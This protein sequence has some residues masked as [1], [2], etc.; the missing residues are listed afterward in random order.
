[1]KKFIILLEFS[2]L[3]FTSCLGQN[4]MHNSVSCN[5]KIIIQYDKRS[6][7]GKLSKNNRTSLTIIF[8][9]FFN[10]KI[11][12]YINGKLMFDDSVITNENTGKTNKGF[13]YNYGKERISPVLKIQ[14]DD[15]NCFEIKMKKKYKFT[16]IFYD[17]DKGWIV[18]F[19]NKYYVD[20]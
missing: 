10:G 8:M 4:G 11:K 18:R 14:K 12:G 9:N 5:K 17:L 1:M 2:I 7:R 6:F 13:V 3:L 19:S 20:N 16:Y 15:G